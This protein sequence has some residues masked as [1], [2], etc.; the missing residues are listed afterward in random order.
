MDEFQKNNAVDWTSYD[1]NT[2]CHIIRPKKVKKI[3][4]RLAHKKSRRNLKK[5]L[6]E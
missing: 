3:L 1:L 4:K 2:K 5:C 6:T